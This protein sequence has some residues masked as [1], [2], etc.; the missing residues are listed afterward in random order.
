[1]SQEEAP[2]STSEPTYDDLDGLN[3]EESRSF[4]GRFP[5]RL[6]RYLHQHLVQ[7]AREQGVS[8]NQFVC[9][10]AVRAAEA[11]S[12]A[13][14]LRLEQGTDRVSREEYSRIWRN[15]WG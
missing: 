1:M 8:L 6:P 13:K 3:P 9:T 5:V 14:E 15:T 12:G 7:V 10:A 11:A 4:S 2:V